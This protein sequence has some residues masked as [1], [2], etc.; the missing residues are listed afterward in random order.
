M[1]LKEVYIH[2]YATIEFLDQ[3]KLFS[4]VLGLKKNFLQSPYLCNTSYVIKEEEENFTG[5]NGVPG[6]QKIS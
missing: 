2:T 6:S 3:Q 4:R 1:V 5:S